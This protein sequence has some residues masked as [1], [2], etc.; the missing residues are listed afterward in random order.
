MSFSVEYST[1]LR[2]E[3]EPGKKVNILPVPCSTGYATHDIW[4]ISEVCG[5]NILRNIGQIFLPKTYNF[6]TT[7]YGLC[8]KERD[9]SRHKVIWGSFDK[10]KAFLIRKYRF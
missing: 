9:S 4:I 8:L 7:R 5:E 1:D 3:I 6:P 10:L 2:S